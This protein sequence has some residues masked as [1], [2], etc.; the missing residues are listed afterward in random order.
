MSIAVI[1]NPYYYTPTHRTRQA[2]TRDPRYQYIH[3]TPS[4][5]DVTDRQKLVNDAAAKFRDDHKFSEKYTDGFINSQLQDEI[6]PDIL[7]EVINEIYKQV[8]DR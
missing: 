5:Q 8:S 2:Q 6:I 1:P 7:I 4:E 3:V